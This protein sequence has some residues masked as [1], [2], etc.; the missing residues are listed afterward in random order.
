MRN[1]LALYIDE[2][3]RDDEEK[4]RENENYKASI[5]NFQFN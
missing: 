1:E 2:G 4:R 5:N 3:G